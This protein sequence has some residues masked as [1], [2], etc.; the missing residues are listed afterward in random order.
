M[1]THTPCMLQTGTLFQTD[2]RGNVEATHRN[3]WIGSIPQS[4]PNI[5]SS[6]GNEIKGVESML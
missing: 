5:L 3:P 1:P 6:L 4:G 2:G